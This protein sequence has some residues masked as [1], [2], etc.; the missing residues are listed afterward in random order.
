MA[1]YAGGLFR[2]FPLIGI[3]LTGF[4]MRLLKEIQVHE[5]HAFFKG[6]ATF[7]WQPAPIST[8][9]SFIYHF[10]LVQLLMIYFPFSK[11]MHTIGAV[12]SKMVARS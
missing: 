4:H 3:A 11:L 2:P 1:L 10:A 12:F 9:A 8:G 7:N 6:L 5:L